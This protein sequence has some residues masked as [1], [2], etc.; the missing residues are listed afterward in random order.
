MLVELARKFALPLAT[1]WVAAAIGCSGRSSPLASGAPPVPSPSDAGTSAPPSP[2]F[3]A[4]PA[5]TYVAKVKG[6]LVGLPPTDDEVTAVGADPTRLKTLVNGWMQLPEY[7]EKMLRFFE[8]SFQQ[9]QIT[10]SDF[11]DQAY[12]RQIAVN[13]TTTPLLLQNAQES[14]ARTMLELVAEQHS[15]TE[16]MTTH[17][18][19]LTTA[20]KEL[21]AFLDVWQVDDNGKVTDRFRQAG[22]ALT[23]T[24]GTAQGPIPIEETLDPASPNYM[25]WYNPDAAA[26]DQQ[27]AGCAADPIVYPAS[28]LTLHWL[29]YGSLENR[30][31]AGG[32]GCPQFAGSAAAPQLTFADFNDW[33]LVTVR[34]PQASETS[35]RFY[36]LPALRGA[37]ELVLSIPRVGFFSTPAFFANWC[38]NTSNQMR[39]TMNQTL[40]VA[41]GSSVDGTDVTVTPG[42]PPPGVDAVHASSAAC[43]SCHQTLDPL[44]SIFSATYSWNYHN[45]VDPALTAE[46]GLFSFRGVTQPV[47]SMDDLGSA[48]SHHPLF[49]SAW[50]EKLCYYVNSAPCAPAD[51]EFQRIVK[52]FEDSNDSW[53][54]LVA[55]LLSSPVT[56]NAVETLTADTNG[57]VVAVARRDHL[58]AAL[59]NRLGFTDVCGRSTLTKKQV[60][61]VASIASGLPSDGY[62]RGSTNPILPNQPNLFYRAGVE[63]MCA[64]VAAQVIDVA[65]GRQLPNVR[66]WSSAAPDA[67][68]A[69]FVGTVM[70]L[71]SSDPRAAPAAQLLKAH[72]TA[73]L[74]QGVSASD[75]LKS[76]FVTACLSPSSVSIGL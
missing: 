52:A 42:N 34:P 29:L 58:C 19:M 65:A 18:F 46:K 54:T 8:L 6:V 17:Q 44:R 45:Q 37:S 36:D 38:T 64:A 5:S 26:E 2:S 49:A 59:D 16:A 51:P 55:E 4:V 73:A 56:T 12:P 48:L 30:R 75:A 23:I 7:Q 3:Q 13:A 31:G 35:T 28:A 53:N 67:A 33:T 47:T 50:A 24:V 71:A 22:P 66:Q 27:I 14:F 43:F 9:T 20:L 21:Y 11:A 72:F 63:N 39:V 15:L 61:L 74:Q 41:L 70:A 32:V 60:P 62:G 25:H 10:A 40:I 1:S 69:D 76:T 68:I 57:E